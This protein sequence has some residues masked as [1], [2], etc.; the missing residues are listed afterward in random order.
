MVRGQQVTRLSR[1]NVVSDSDYGDPV[2][3]PS[4]V[5][6]LLDIRRRSLREKGTAPTVAVG[7]DLPNSMSL[8]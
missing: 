7:T 1:H 2:S 6:S 3:C 4:F 5:C 8:Y